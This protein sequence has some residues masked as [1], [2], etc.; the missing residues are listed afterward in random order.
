LLGAVE[1]EIPEIA[2]DGEVFE[3]YGEVFGGVPGLLLPRPSVENDIISCA[4]NKLFSNILR[5][6]TQYLFILTALI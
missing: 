1:A 6:A 5:Q 4:L 3:S 2:V